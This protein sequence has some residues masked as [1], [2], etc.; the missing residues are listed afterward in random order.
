M[1]KE[2]R[3]A[4]LASIALC[5]FSTVPCFGQPAVLHDWTGTGGAELQ[6]SGTSGVAND[7]VLVNEGADPS[8]SG[9]TATV[10]NGPAGGAG[11]DEGYINLGNVAGFIDADYFSVQWKDL[12]LNLTNHT[13]DIVLGGALAPGTD[14]G[15]QSQFFANNCSVG[16]S[17]DVRVI[18]YEAG[19]GWLSNPPPEVSDDVTFTAILPD[20]PSDLRIVFEGNGSTQASG[21][22]GTVKAF[23]N[24]SQ[25]GGTQSIALGIIGNEAGGSDF[26]LGKYHG[27]SSLGGEYTT[28]TFSISFVPEPQSIC[29]F[30][31]GCGML[32]A[33]RRR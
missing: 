5:L 23:V 33:R 4:L 21:G 7:A 31:V 22:S 6:N 17:C 11:V 26:G 18:L 1:I 29:L 8:I 2:T 32:L 12:D 9:G 30:L 25:A 15:S 20:T 14:S 16:G 19:G 13:T 24:G 10:V 3:S 27:G 28:G